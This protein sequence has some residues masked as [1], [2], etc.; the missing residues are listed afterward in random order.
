MITVYLRPNFKRQRNARGD[1]TSGMGKFFPSRQV[2]D[3]IYITPFSLTK[4]RKGKLSQTISLSQHGRR[5][6]S[7]DQVTCKLSHLGGYIHIGNT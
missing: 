7:Q 3:Y 4:Q 6:L 1:K 2:K 5:G